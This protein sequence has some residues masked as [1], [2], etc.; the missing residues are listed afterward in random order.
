MKKR[1]AKLHP[2]LLELRRA[3]IKKYGGR[4]KK[5]VLFGSY[6]RGDYT[7]DS[8]M[9]VLI[10]LEDLNSGYKEISKLVPLIADLN[11]KYGELASCIAVSRV[12]YEKGRSPL[13]VNVHREGI[14][15]HG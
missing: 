12:D 11:L 10:V 5:I 9:D 7:S 1:N 3:L 14:A 4:L 2:M 6:A 13:L 8:D 15:L